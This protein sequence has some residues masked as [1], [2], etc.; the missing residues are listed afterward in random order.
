[1]SKV[2]AKIIKWVVKFDFWESVSSPIIH[3]SLK[4][5]V[6]YQNRNTKD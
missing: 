4:F 5:R 6:K 2:I 3:A 1:M